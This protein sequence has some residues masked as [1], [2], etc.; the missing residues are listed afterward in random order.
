MKRITSVAIREFVTQ[1][2]FDERIILGKDSSWPRISIVTPSFNQAQFIE[3]TILSVLNQNYPNLEYIIIDGGSTDGSVEIIKK[4][5]K[6]LTYWV[7]EPDEGQSD[8]INKGFAQ[9]TGEILAWLNSDDTYLPNVLMK[10]GEVFKMKH[11]IDVLT[12]DMYITDIH[13]M[14]IRAL[15]EV[16][17]H[18]NAVIYGAHNINQQATFWRRTILS[19]LGWLRQDLHYCMDVDLLLRSVLM[20]SKFYHLSEMMATFRIQPHMKSSASE[21]FTVESIEIRRQLLG[22][23]IKGV[24]YRIMKRLYSLRRL[25]YFFIKGDLYYIT[26]GLRRK[27]NLK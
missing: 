14:I 17:F 4:Y 18:K 16:P 20:N 8:A 11:T 5:E 26:D 12:G 1:P 15:K 10:V 22:G 7:S 9:S 3:R 6:Y 25:M 21:K 27:L 24:N 19:R 23:R 2:L 13:D